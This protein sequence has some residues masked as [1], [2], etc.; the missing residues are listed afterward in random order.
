MIP[1]L[2]LG[3]CSVSLGGSSRYI[4][5]EGGPPNWGVSFIWAELAWPLNSREEC[6]LS[7]VSVR[8]RLVPCLEPASS[9]PLVKG[10]AGPP[11]ACWGRL[12]KGG[13]L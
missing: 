13:L 5:Q 7:L 8:I 11:R 3:C 2:D 4:S 12:L 10:R 9:K 1:G 6:A